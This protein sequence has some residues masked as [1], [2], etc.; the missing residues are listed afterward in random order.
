MEKNILAVAVSLALVGSVAAAEGNPVVITSDNST[1]TQAKDAV[2][3]TAFQDQ[4]IQGATG[5]ETL[6]IEGS[7]TEGIY[8]AT[9]NGLLNNFPVCRCTSR[10]SRIKRKE[11]MDYMRPTGIL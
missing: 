2:A 7:Y 6:T 5:A 8:A 1:Y 11:S 3:H 9:T 4:S 10:K